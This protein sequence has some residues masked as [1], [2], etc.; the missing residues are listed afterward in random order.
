ML[1]ATNFGTNWTDA[2]VGLRPLTLARHG[3]LPHLPFT[4]P[5][6]AADDERDESGKP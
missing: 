4:Y 3:Q 5:W 1:D 2:R 6:V